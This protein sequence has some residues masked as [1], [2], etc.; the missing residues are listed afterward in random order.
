MIL[1][2]KY[3]TIWLYT[4]RYIIKLNSTYTTIIYASINIHFD[5]SNRGSRL[6]IVYNLNAGRCLFFAVK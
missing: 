6:D 1:V 3:N 2:E 5:H 4:T